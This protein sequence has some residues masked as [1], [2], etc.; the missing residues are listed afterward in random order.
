MTHTFIE[1]Q[2][3][4]RTA[5]AAPGRR[6]KILIVEDDEEQQHIL[7]L[8]LENAGHTVITAIAGQKALAYSDLSAP[9]LI[10]LDIMLASHMD[11]LKVLSKLKANVQTASIP[12][13]I[14]SAYLSDE[15]IERLLESDAALYMTKPYDMTIL[16]K[17]VQLLLEAHAPEAA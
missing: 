15:R 13:M 1:E 9:D 5:L 8:A 3:Q 4:A 16:L 6:R 17:N 10:L 11:G 14:L 7:R 2:P 12:V